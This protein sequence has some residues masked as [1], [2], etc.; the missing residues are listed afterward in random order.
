MVRHRV[1]AWLSGLLAALL[2][3]FTVA[4]P[5]SAATNTSIGG[6]GNGLKI[7]PVTTDITVSAGQSK[8]VTVYAQNV[9]TATVTL[10]VLVN[11]FTANG[12]ESGTPALLLNSNQYAPSHSLK[13]FVTPLSNVTL[14]P[15]QQKGVNVVISI[16]ANAAAGGYYGAVRFAPAATNTTS[17]VTLSAS[18]GSL[19]LVRVPGTIKE[20]VELL[21][22]DVRRSITGSAEAIFT[23]NKSLTAVARFHNIGDVQEQPF[24]K[25][26][27]KRGS[28]TLATYEINNTTPRGNVLPGSIRRFGVTLD[29]VGSFGKYTIIGN[30]GYGTNGQLLSGQTTFYV[31]P[32]AAILLLILVIVAILFLIFVLPRL[33]RQYNRRIIRK[34]GR[35]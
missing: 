8:T 18:V 21:S 19:I 25:V 10:Q 16:P 27:L 32:L 24:G 15:G 28:K 14:Q 31:V 9:T 13:R 29:K 12:D 2:F 33:I 22:L 26:L 34:A 5:A 35:R 20:N 7:S 23:N 6:T 30:F 4:L 17:N 11:D 3:V 1:I